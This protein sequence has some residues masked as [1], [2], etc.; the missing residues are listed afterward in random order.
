VAHVDLAHPLN[1]SVLEYIGVTDLARA[2]A[3]PRSESALLSLSTHPDL[4]EYLWSLD[5]ASACT[6]D[7]RSPPL[8]SHG[9][10]GVI[11][12]LARGT[13][14]LAFR[15]PEPELGQAL[16]VPGYGHEYRYPSG[17]V[18]AAEIGEGW[19][20]VRPFAPLNP[21]WCARAFAHAAG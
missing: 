7:G 10:S 21:A 3:V 8:L 12:G 19:A 1:A 15:L 16:E 17:P 6:I 9:A 2:R 20:L 18:R 14:T 5:A 13:S 11:F 4:V